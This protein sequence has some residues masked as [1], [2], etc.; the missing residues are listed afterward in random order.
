[1]E[2]SATSR[3]IL[4]QV[5]E[6]SG[7]PVEIITDSDLPYLA[8]ITR[9]RVASPAHILRVRDS[10]EAPDYHVAYEAGFILRLYET[11]AA[12]RVEFAGTDAG[13]SA[14]AE[15]VR[16]SGQTAR[17]PDAA[18]SQLVTQLYDGLVIQLRSYPIGLR[19][20]HWLY[21]AYPD[22]HD[23]QRASIER[24]QRD[25]LTALSPE[26]RAFAPKA[27]WEANVAMNAAYAIFCD[28]LFDTKAFAIPWRSTGLEKRGRRL[29]D[30]AQ[31]VPDD[32]AH[33]RQLVD[34]WA[35]ELGLDGWY[36]WVPLRP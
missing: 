9:A 3:D 36:Q 20:D 21:D 6:A 22:F 7:Y 33:D 15:M 35:T 23:G 18:V 17:L 4:R 13:R 27:V 16:R 1:M 32:A 8:R 19:I 28:R 26:V 29:L 12:E 2:L 34:A 25:N 24:Q 31:S 10:S 30:I 14:V 5:E 11:P